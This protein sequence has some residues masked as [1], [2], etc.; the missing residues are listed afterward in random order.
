ML[1][2]SAVL[3][4]WFYRHSGQPDPDRLTLYGNIDIR[5]VN[6]SFHDPEH[7]EQI[8]VQEGERVKQ[9]QLL[10]IQD[11]QRFQYAIDSAA[12]RLAQQQQVMNRLLNG[13][14]PE[15]IAKARADVK[16]A[17]AEVDFAGKELKR[18]QTLSRKKLASIEAA[19]RARSE[20][21]SAREKLQAL[22]ELHALTVIGPRQEDIEAAR[23]SLRVEQTALKLAKKSGRTPIFMRRT[24]ASSRTACSSR[25]TWRMRKRRCLP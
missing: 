21:D 15:E 6:L 25:A 22:R 20:L 18:L 24:T 5:Q 19:D 23:A 4:G 14:R 3:A 1:F 9:G 8:V 12:A 10:A 16:A 17:E 13:S 2:I 11:L 7:I